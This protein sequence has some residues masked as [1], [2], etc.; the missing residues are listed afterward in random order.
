MHQDINKVDN[1]EI[2]NN[3]TSNKNKSKIKSSNSVRFQ[4]PKC[5]LNSKSISHSY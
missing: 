4:K 1:Y 2:I 5:E 3:I